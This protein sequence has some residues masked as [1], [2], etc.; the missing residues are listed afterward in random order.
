MK[1]GLRMRMGG[2][3]KI[4]NERKKME[5]GEEKKKESRNKSLLGL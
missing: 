4:K 5:E 2:K 1:V 3:N